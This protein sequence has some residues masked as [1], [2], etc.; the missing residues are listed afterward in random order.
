MIFDELKNAAQY[1]SLH[2]GF[3]AA[4]DFLSRA[5]FST[6]E[7]GKHIIDGERVYAS[8]ATN[9]ARAKSEARLEAH[10]RYIDIQHI[11]SGT[12]EIGYLG[13]SDCK[14]PSGEYDA[15]RDIIFFKE[16]PG[17]WLPLCPRNFAV[18][19][20]A[21]AHAPG[22]TDKSVRKVVLKVAVE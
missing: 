12:E 21:D 19:M 22:V 6:L 2:P 3:K 17:I 14:M 10:R 18:F 11:F 8:V 5:N 16:A 15:E 20:P 1:F 4:F 7:D 13:L 9:G